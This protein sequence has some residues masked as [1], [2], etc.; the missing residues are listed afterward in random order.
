VEAGGVAVL[1]PESATCNEFNEPMSVFPAAPGQ[2]QVGKGWV[3]RFKECEG[4]LWREASVAL[5]RANPKAAVGHLYWYADF[6]ATHR[7]IVCQPALELAKVGRPV[8]VSAPVVIAEP[9]V[10]AKGV[11]VPLV[12]MRTMYKKG[13][14]TYEKL[15]VTLADGRA[16]TKAWSSRQGALKLKRQGAAVS[17]TLPLDCTDIVVFGR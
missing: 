1:G 7:D 16:V 8:L 15:E 9:L 2:H 12:N 13:G 6:D 14:T 3:V 4:K 11:A 10:S 5:N 17:V